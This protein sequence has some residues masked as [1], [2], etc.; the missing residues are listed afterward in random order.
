MITKQLLKETAD[1]IDEGIA[2]SASIML[3]VMAIGVF[4]H[5]AMH[6]LSEVHDIVFWVGFFGVLFISIFTLETASERVP[7]ASIP[8]VL[9]VS[10]LAFVANGLYFLDIATDLVATFSVFVFGLF[11]IGS[12][13]SAILR[14][15]SREAD[16]CDDFQGENVLLEGDE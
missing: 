15:F 8:T 10:I 3:L 9:P 1:E 16:V 4:I 12:V 13:T 11:V 14:Y 6:L 7:F 2:G 5:T